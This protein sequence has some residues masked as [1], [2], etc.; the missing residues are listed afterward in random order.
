MVTGSG[1]DQTPPQPTYRLTLLV[2]SATG[3]TRYVA[4]Y[5]RHSLEPSPME[6][7]A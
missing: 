1:Q 2:F 3:N 7:E 4:E 5:L 6:V